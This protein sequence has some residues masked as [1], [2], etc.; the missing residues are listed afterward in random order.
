MMSELTL[1]TT[2][3]QEIK[4]EKPTIVDLFHAY[5]SHEFGNDRWN[6]FMNHKEFNTMITHYQPKYGD[7]VFSVLADTVSEI[8]NI[9]IKD[10]LRN[11]SKFVR[12]YY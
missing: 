6:E 3:D 10:L 1:K 11:F 4:D 12:T 8:Q 5:C 2:K 7:L 9:S